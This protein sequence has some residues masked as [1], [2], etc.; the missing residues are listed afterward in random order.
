MNANDSAPGWVNRTP[1]VGQSISMPWVSSVGGT[2]W[3]FGQVCVP[4]REMITRNTFSTSLIVPTVL[5]SPG[6]GGRCRS[7]RAAGRWSIRSASGRCAWLSRR[8]L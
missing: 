4:S 7:A 2:W 8:R 1:Q 3:P 5:R 6:T